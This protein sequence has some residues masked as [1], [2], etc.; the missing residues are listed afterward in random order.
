M[1]AISYGD[2]FT[3]LDVSFGFQGDPLIFIKH[4]SGIGATAV[5][6]HRSHEEKGSGSGAIHSKRI[7]VKNPSDV[8]YVV[9]SDGI[10]SLHELENGP[11]DSTTRSTV[12]IFSVVMLEFL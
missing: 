8:D 3:N 6:D 4:N 2:F 12:W 1:T 7:G 5:I 11:K 10:I 9:D